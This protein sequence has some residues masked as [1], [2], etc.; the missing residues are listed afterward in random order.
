LVVFSSAYPNHLNK[1]IDIVD[2]KRR[3]KHRLYLHHTIRSF[4]Q[5]I[6]DV[7]RLGRNL[8]K[9]VLVEASPVNTGAGQQ[10]RLSQDNTIPVRAWTGGSKDTLLAEL[11]P[12]LAMVV[13][14]NMDAREAVRKYRE[15]MEK[16]MQSGVKYINFGMNL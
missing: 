7:G 11:C 8:N 16:N 3:V 15:Q 10:D 14:K 6:K 13:I 9:V 12:I 4:G 2:R 5:F 1:V